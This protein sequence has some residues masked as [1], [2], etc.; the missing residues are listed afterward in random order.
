MWVFLGILYGLTS[1]SID[2]QQSV[3]PTGLTDPP[4]TWGYLIAL[5]ISNLR[6]NGLRIRIRRRSVPLKIFDG[7]KYCPVMRGITDYTQNRPIPEGICSSS[8][9]QQL[10]SVSEMKHPKRMGPRKYL[11]QSSGNGHVSLIKMIQQVG[12]I[13][14]NLAS[15][16]DIYIYYIQ[17]IDLVS[18]FV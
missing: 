5:S 8:Y 13:L 1:V 10:L 14:T 18:R 15:T 7:M 9:H 6:F 2:N 17:Y 3:G 16:L 4:T 11:P 12:S